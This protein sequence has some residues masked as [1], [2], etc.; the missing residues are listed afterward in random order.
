VHVLIDAIDPGYR[1]KMMVLAVRRTLL[2]KLD[3]VGAVEMIDL[4]DGL[5]VGRDNVH[6]LFDLRCIWHKKTPENS[7]KQRL[8]AKKVA[9]ANR[10]GS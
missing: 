2:G 4:S 5:P 9:A 7:V 10:H 1:D 8:L 6:V 3:L